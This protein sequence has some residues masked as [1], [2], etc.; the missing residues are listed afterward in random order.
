M[1]AEPSSHYHRDVAN[2]VKFVADDHL[3]D[4]LIGQHVYS[5]PSACVRELL[6]NAADACELQRAVDPALEPHISVTYSP[7][8]N[9]FE[10]ED[11]G[12]GMDDETFTESFRRV[13]AKKAD[14]EQIKR[15]M[16]GA[17]NPVRQLATFGIGILSC[18]QVASEVLVFAKM[19]SA[20][21]LAYRIKGVHEDFELLEAPRQARGTCI[22]LALRADAGFSATDVPAAV[23]AFARHVPYIEVRN[24][25]DGSLVHMSDEW[26]GLLES[27]DRTD[28]ASDRIRKG[29]LGLAEAWN[30]HQAALISR[31]RVTNGGFLLYENTSALIPQPACG[32]IGEIDLV[33]GAL[34]LN[35]NRES[36]AEDDNWLSL[37]RELAGVLDRLL[38]QS[39]T[40]AARQTPDVSQAALERNVLLLGQI[41]DV[42]GTLPNAG[43]VAGDL[44]PNTV[45]LPIW[46]AR[47]GG[48]SRTS[49]DELVGQPGT[50]KTIYVRRENTGA[51]TIATSQGD[52]AGTVQIQERVQTKDIRAS[53]VRARGDVVV[54]TNLRSFTYEG[55]G[56]THTA[57][58]DEWDLLSRLA[59]A[60]EAKV[61][62]VSQIPSDQLL[63]QKSFESDLVTGILDLGEALKL[64][65]LPDSPE[66]IVRDFD[67][68]LLNVAHPKVRELLHQ[69]PQILTNPLRTELLRVYFELLQYR[70]AE[71]RE[72]L[73]ALL[74][75]PEF[76]T[77]AQMH[78]YRLL[79]GYLEQELEAMDRTTQS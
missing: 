40:A 37:G 25:D 47:P 42:S 77:K 68:R 43:R 17:A 4:L 9:W 28:L 75:D 22:R 38:A 29:V 55:G 16:E 1:T 31:L 45:T 3:L 49:I 50:D 73:R 61:V 78:S 63:R 2:G 18:F 58:L 5:H 69:L 67:G 74:L 62:D 48:R 39:V 14:V 15:I 53:L 56:S 44:I 54:S 23:S 26:L 32:Y 66:E 76:D 24:G 12:L 11:N 79:K 70:S 36:A 41:L 34:T 65:R 46:E 33:P 30:D 21:A 20:D 64:A 19:D 59:A 7:S 71:A 8:G 27:K 52:G 60:S 35:L 10:V 57:N 13:G 51:P 6:Q 72:F